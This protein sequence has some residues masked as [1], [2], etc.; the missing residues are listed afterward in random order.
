M[1]R[2]VVLIGN[3][4]P[5]SRTAAAARQAADCLRRTL[6][7]YD[8]GLSEPEV[9]DLAAFPTALL[10]PDSDRATV[11]R[12]LR[13]VCTADLLVVASPT[14]KATYS[15]L[16]KVFLDQV[17]R[18]GLRGVLALPLMVAAD[19]AHRH[20]VEVYLRPLLVELGATVPTPGIFVL[21]QR[22]G[23]FDAVFTEWSAGALPTLADTL[24]TA[25]VVRIDG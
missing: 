20:A 15:G 5:H 11:E 9:I 2:L 17:P 19:V 10:G 22:L 14:F 4:K 24:N 12:A 21:E 16:L 7:G 18:K 13:S 25:A 3:P 23:A 1:S 8:A 6:G